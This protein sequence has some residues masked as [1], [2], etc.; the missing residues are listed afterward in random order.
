MVAE[1]LVTQRFLA[2]SRGSARFTSVNFSDFEEDMIYGSD[3]NLPRPFFLTAAEH[4]TIC[5]DLVGMFN[6]LCEL[7]RRLF[8]GNVQALARAVALPAL[9]TEAVMRT[10][11]E[12]PVL[13]GRSDLYRDES[14]FKMLEYNLTSA[15]GGWQGTL[16]NRAMLHDPT[17]VEFVAEEGLTYSD[18]L[19]GLVRTMMASCLLDDAPERPYVALTDWPTSFPMEEER[20]RTM[21]NYMNQMGVDVEIC[22]MGHFE[23]KDDYVFLG[24]RRVDVIFR[25]YLLDH[26]LKG[27]DPEGVLRPMLRAVE[28]GKVGICSPFD[29]ELYGNKACFALL[30]DEQYRNSFTAVEKELIDRFIPRTYQLHRDRLD[31]AR[32]NRHRLILKPNCEYDGHG[33]TAGWTVEPEDWADLLKSKV[34]GPYIVQERVKPTPERYVDPDAPDEY[35]ETILN[36]GMFASVSMRDAGG[37]VKGIDDTNAGVVAVERGARFG[38]VFHERPQ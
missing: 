11:L 12:N 30:H 27:P 9:Q 20:L 37:Y 8:G 13:I 33:I 31:F 7:P 4:E 18:C 24:G 5:A 16:L 38:C 6:L 3:R 32:E 26:V 29:T 35:R 25:M 21:A 36:W 23:Y 14:G 1:N 22:H 15:L 28:R 2:E 19:L 34:G 10:G 17:L